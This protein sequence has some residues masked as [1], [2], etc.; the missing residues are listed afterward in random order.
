MIGATHDASP[1]DPDGP[2]L[3][4]GVAGPA[5]RHPL[6]GA[7]TLLAAQRCSSRHC[8]EINR[9]HPL[10]W[11]IRCGLTAIRSIVRAHR[12]PKYQ[13]LGPTYSKR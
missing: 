2:K 1:I 13:N 7:A 5:L 3:A 10:D 4:K 9:A 8:S 11:L 12:I 6:A